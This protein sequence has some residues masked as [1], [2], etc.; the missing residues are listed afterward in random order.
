MEVGNIEE[1]TPRGIRT[2]DAGEIGLDVVVFAT[3]FNVDAS[4][5]PF[6]I[7]GRGARDLHKQWADC[8]TAMNGT[9]VVCKL[10]NRSPQIK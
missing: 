5:R 6:R 10:Q 8:P 2:A 7:V 9:V 3:G 4:Y 1:F